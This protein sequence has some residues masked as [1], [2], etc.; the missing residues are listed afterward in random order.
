MAEPNR[1]RRM[2]TRTILLLSCLLGGLVT[3][4]DDKPTKTTPSVEPKPDTTVVVEPPVSHLSL[5]FAGDIMFHDSQVKGA[6]QP[7][8]T[9]DF[10]PCLADISDEVKRAD[11]AIANLETTLSGPPYTGYPTF[12]SPDAVLQ[13]T[14]DAGFDIFLTANNH[15]LAG[16]PR[17][18]ERTLVV[19]D[20]LQTL[21]L[22]TYRNPEE[23]DQSYP[24]LI[25]RN[26]FRIVLL[27]FT[28]A[29]NGIK[30]KGTQ[31]VNYMDTI[32]L[33]QDL[34]KAHLMRPDVIIALPHW[35]NEYQTLPSVKQKKMAQWLL[36]KGVD[37]II[38]SHPHVAQPLEL[39]PD[40]SLLI[41]W[42]MGNVVSNMQRIATSGGYMVRMEFSKRDGT[43]R[44]SDCGYTCYWMSRPDDN[45]FSKPHRVMRFSTP[46][47]L[48]T[49]RERGKRR[50]IDTMLHNLLNSHNQ[51]PIKEYQ[52]E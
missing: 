18:L 20:S 26:G 35:G 38:G 34:E 49:D 19:M 10:S 24:L 52:M 31:I 4:C 25:E 17:G 47:S 14:L 43:T 21:H 36:D 30:P 3:A 12:R 27:N 8:G 5:L 33:A 46:D 51:G 15:C 2:R 6:L 42:S 28:Y 45:D 9:Y 29:T 39:S 23:R 13:A 44:L 40:S 32:Q 11:I 1:K 16:G 41:A 37:H 22:G 48:L 7:D 50:V